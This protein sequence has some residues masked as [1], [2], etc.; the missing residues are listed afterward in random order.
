MGGKHG[1]F[2]DVSFLQLSI[3]KEAVHALVI[4]FH[5]L[6][7]RNPSGLRWPLPQG[8]RG[9][10]KTKLAFDGALIDPRAVSVVGAQIFHRVG[11]MLG[12][13]PI[14]HDGVMAV[15][16]DEPVVKPA[17]AIVAHFVEVQARRNVRQGHALPSVTAALHAD[18]EGVA[19]DFRGKQFEAQNP[20]VGHVVHCAASSI[21]E[22]KVGA[23][24]PS[25]SRI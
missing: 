10:L 3:R 7:P 14:G 25:C 16:Q 1:R 22:A 21:R 24:S 9:D 11:T 5:P 12:Q 6:A 19:A 15:G 17:F 4:A 20:L 23:S 18:V 8:A 2:P 13:R